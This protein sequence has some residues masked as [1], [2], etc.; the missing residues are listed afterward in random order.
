VP[1]LFFKGFWFIKNLRLERQYRGTGT[2]VQRQLSG[3]ETFVQKVPANFLNIGM[4]VQGKKRGRAILL[5]LRPPESPE[6][7]DTL[8]GA[9]PVAG[10]K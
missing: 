2:L 1:L 4:P 3:E 10:I 7:P 6:V 9:L 5:A 8:E